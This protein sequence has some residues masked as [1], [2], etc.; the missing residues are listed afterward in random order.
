MSDGLFQKTNNT[1]MLSS[2][3]E[4]RNVITGGKHWMKCLKS[5]ITQNF[6]KIRMTEKKDNS[7]VQNLLSRRNNN[8]DDDEITEEICARNKRVIMEQISEM[9]D[10]SG[11]FSRLKMWKIKQRLCPKNGPSV[12]VAKKDTFGNLVTNRKQL[13]ELYVSCYKNRLRHRTIR[14][15]YS[16][17]KANK[18]YLFSLR[19]K[20]SKTVKSS[21]W[22]HKDLLKVMKKL[23]VNKAADP[24]GLVNE[25]F[26]PGVAGSD[27]VNSVLTLCNMIRSECQIP[28]F[29]ELANITSIYK[30]KGSKQDLDNDRGIFSVTC[31][32]SIVDNLIYNDYYEIIDSN[33]SDSN[34]GGRRN[35]SI[36]DNLFI[37]YGVI[38]N[39]LQ[40]KLNLDLS[41][42]DIAK[43]FDSQWHAETM[44]DLWDVGV[45]DNKFAV[46]SEMNSRC[47]ISVRT[48]V[49]LTERF[50]LT[51]IEMQG[52]V[53]GPI[54]CSVQLDTLG[55]D[56][57][58]RQEGLYWYNDC[59]AVPPLQMI[60]DLAS[61]SLCSPDSVIT[62]AIINGKIEAKKLEFGPAKCYNIHI[63]DERKCCVGLKVHE[64]SINR[65]SH[66]TYLGDI[67]CYTGSNIK[68]VEKRCNSGI[69][70]VSQILSILNRVSLGHFYY[71]MALVFRDTMLVSKLVSSSEAWYN[72]TDEQYSKLEEI[73]EM[74]MMQVLQLPQSTPRLSLYVECGRIPL[75][76]IIKSRRLMYYW[77]I[78]NL[79]ENELLYK[80][81]LAQSLRPV[82]N[83]WA[84]Q[85]LED[86][87]DI[88]ITLSD[89]EVKN[90]TQ[91]KFHSMIKRQIN[92]SAM[93]H[94]QNIQSKQSKTKHLQID[95]KFEPAEY[96]TSEVLSPSEIQT[97]FRLRSRCIN[98][99]GN[100]RSAFRNNMSCRTCFLVPETQEHVYHCSVI[101]N[102]VSFFNFESVKYEMIFGNLS[103]Q[104]N[105]TKIYHT[106]IQARTDI[107]NNTSSPSP[108]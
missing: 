55:R 107:L 68:N 105:F 53:L 57:Y 42:Y 82:K 62:N 17:M 104:E 54:K 43:C 76:Y 96:L 60:D 13:Q 40:K 92:I 24:L 100:Q 36:R 98:V 20:L 58:E 95:E 21:D 11:H 56:C 106:M 37:V 89:D 86:K 18:E 6:R 91:Y 45:R 19:L 97:L 78:L 31:L 12:P 50:E 85:I 90:I 38:N 1:N 49:G 103:E 67:I 4:N 52:T 88:G 32:R 23:K 84:L 80:F 41:L 63:G 30:N 48:P 69:G 39:A 25:L 5:I 14:P 70:A 87:S 9:S 10:T 22:T 102:K 2:S 34:V 15:E 71:E 73:D 29:A 51:D 59:V 16:Q 7:N 61:F 28:K 101:R 99:K 33:M 72:I 26:K 94:L 83:D 81:Y 46:I 66:E 44:N 75:R 3:L 108:T 64:E 65:K 47:N 79:K 8:K 35:R 77:K 27:L 74:Y 93:N